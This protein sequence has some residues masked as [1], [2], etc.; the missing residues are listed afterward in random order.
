MVTLIWVLPDTYYIDDAFWQLIY[1]LFLC[2]VDSAERAATVAA[3]LISSARLILKLDS[4]FTEY[5]PQFLVDNALVVK[6]PV[7]GP[8]RSTFTTEDCLEHLVDVA[9][10]K[11][12]AELEEMEKRRCKITVKDC[13]ECAFK[14]GIPR[15]EHWAHLGC[16][17]KVPPY[18][19]LMPRVPVKGEVIE[20]KKLEDALELLKHGPI[21]AKLHVFSP[22]IDRVGEDG[23]YQGMAGAETRY[24]GLRDVIIGGVDKVNGVDVA[25]VKICYKKRTSLM[26]V[27]LNR[28]IMLLQHHADES[29]SVEPTRLLVDFIVPRLS[30]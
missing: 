16:V 1:G 22:D 20:V 10:P 29:Q 7:Q 25:T 6:E 23:V 28:M 11:T 9:S 27:A 14:E 17:S 3:N 13:L 15:R 8:P 18:A 4:E 5:S 21:G 2:L 26:K 24:V 19:S 30:K 12:D